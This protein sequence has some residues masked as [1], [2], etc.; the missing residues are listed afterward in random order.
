MCVYRSTPSFLQDFFTTDSA[1][2]SRKPL[3][4]SNARGFIPYLFLI[5]HR[6]KV[7]SFPQENGTMQSY[8]NP[9]PR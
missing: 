2:G 3:S 9:L 8:F 5:V 7:E 6:V 1:S 4:K